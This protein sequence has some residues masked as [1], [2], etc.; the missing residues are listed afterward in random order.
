M[1]E[2]LPTIAL[3][4]N[5]GGSPQ[6]VI[7]SIT[8][9]EGDTENTFDPLYDSETEDGNTTGDIQIIDG[10]IYLRAE[11]IGGSADGRR[12]TFI[13]QAVDAAGNVTRA[14]AEVIVPH[15]QR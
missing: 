9:N 3:T 12:Y 13:M 5:C 6:W 8:I 1:V 10:R 15:D 4:D 2:V 14:A 7:E 11:R